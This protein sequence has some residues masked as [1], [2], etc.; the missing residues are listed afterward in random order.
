MGC[1]ECWAHPARRPR[2]HDDLPH[3]VGRVRRT[4][5]RLRAEAL[6]VAHVRVDD[7]VGAGGVEVVPERLHRVGGPE[8][9]GGSRVKP[10]PVPHGERALSRV[11][12]EIRPEP[13][14]LR[15]ASGG[16]DVGADAVEHDDVPGAEVVAVVTLIRVA[17]RGPEVVEGTGRAGAGVVVV[18]P[19]RGPGSGDVPPPAGSVATLVGG[20]RATGIGVV[21]DGEHRPRDA[22]QQCGRGFVVAA[23]AASDVPRAYENEGPRGRC[24]ARGDRAGRIGPIAVVLEAGGDSRAGRRGEQPSS[25]QEHVPVI[26]VARAV[27]SCPRR[28]SISRARAVQDVTGALRW[29]CGARLRAVVLQRGDMEPSPLWSARHTLALAPLDGAKTI[30]EVH[31]SSQRDTACP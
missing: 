6:I 16:G 31:R 5:R 15:G 17:G 4:T 24:G 13:L 29:G 21:A 2:A 23:G 26:R 22:V 7:Q 25:A 11:R 18:V 9:A 10:G 30:C 19:E 27:K 20:E 12:R 3:P 8:A 1:A 28:N 14:L